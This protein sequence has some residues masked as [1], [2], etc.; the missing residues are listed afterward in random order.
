MLKQGRAAVAA[1]FVCAGAAFAY[2]APPSNID[3][4]VYR[5]GE[6]IGHHRVNFW[7][8]GDKTV[9]DVEIKLDIYFGPIRV[10]A[11][12]HKSRE[13]WKDGALVSLEGSTDN[14]GEPMKAIVRREGDALKIEGTAFSGTA[15]PALLPS[16]WWDYDLMRQ[17][18]IIDTQNGKVFPVSV[19]RIGDVTLTVAGQQ[20]AATHY[21]LTGELALDIW[22]DA[23]G[24]WLRSEFDGQGEIIAY[25]RQSLP[26]QQARVQP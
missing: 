23:Q 6:E 19:Q 15:G 14:D 21:R 24:N 11:Y 13:V 26:Q 16:S 9:A 4:K 18:Q 10:Y 20:V 22:Y 25:E 5:G 2:P 8:D 3:F 17:S 12:E 7:R 1:L